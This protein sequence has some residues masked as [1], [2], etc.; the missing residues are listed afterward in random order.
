MSTDGTSTPEN[1][2]GQPGATAAGT[3]TAPTADQTPDTAGAHDPAT[4]E[5]GD[6][7]WVSRHTGTLIAL[8]VA[9]IVVAVAITGLI[10]WRDRIADRN[11]DTEAAFRQSVQSQGAEVST[12]ECHG[13]ICSAII[14][15]S[16]Y[17]VLVQEDED[18][19]QQFGV[20]AF[21]GR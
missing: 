21:S 16:A 7:G 3:T 8:M 9:V 5:E 1:T 2:P 13:D 19:V 14:G 12:V 4:G 17:T 20:A 18:G 10:L 15:G 6:P 11:A